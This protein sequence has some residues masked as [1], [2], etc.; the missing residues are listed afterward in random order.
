MKTNK[1]NKRTFRWK[2]QT[3]SVSIHKKRAKRENVFFGRFI[4]KMKNIKIKYSL[5]HEHFLIKKEK[6]TKFNKK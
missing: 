2:K 3:N 4:I 6:L 5:T 1:K